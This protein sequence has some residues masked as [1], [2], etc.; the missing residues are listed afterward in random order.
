MTG[1][2]AFTMLGDQEAPLCTDETCV[3]PTSTHPGEDIAR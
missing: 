1:P 2:L 3:V